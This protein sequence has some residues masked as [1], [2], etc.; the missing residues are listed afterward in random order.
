MVVDQIPNLN[1][2]FL[3]KHNALLVGMIAITLPFLNYNIEQHDY[4]YN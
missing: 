1:E 4:A 2:E 3:C